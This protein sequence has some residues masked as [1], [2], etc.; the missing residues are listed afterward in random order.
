MLPLHTSNFF[1]ALLLL[2]L[3]LLF[4]LLDN[5]Y[6]MHFDVFFS[7][8]ETWLNDQ[9]FDHNLFRDNFYI[10]LSDRVSSSKSRGGSVLIAV[11][12]KP[13]ACKRRYDLQF[14]DECV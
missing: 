9:S 3:L 11:S 4:E 13:R 12:S 7:L 10:F 14:Y 1:I 8:T 6:S 2:L 5:V